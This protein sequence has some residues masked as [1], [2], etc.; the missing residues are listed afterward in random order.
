MFHASGIIAAVVAGLVHGFERDAYRS[1][2]YS[3]SNELQSHLEHSRI[4]IEW[5]CFQY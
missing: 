3:T 5:F 4:C 2:T 1:N